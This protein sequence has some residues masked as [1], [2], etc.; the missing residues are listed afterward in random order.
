M[1]PY[2][3]N[4]YKRF[5]ICIAAPSIRHCLFLLPLSSSS[6][7]GSIHLLAGGSHRAGEG[8]G[9]G[10][11]PLWGRGLAGRRPALALE[12]WPLAGWRA[13]VGAAKAARR[14]SPRVASRSRR[15]SA[16]SPAASRSLSPVHPR[17][18]PMRR[19]SRAPPRRQAGHP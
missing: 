18:L 14:A 17:A 6:V 10:N 12:P 3:A 11:T 7:H 1:V 2:P 13:R 8:D 16:A 5:L 15:T 9:E 4:T 19:R